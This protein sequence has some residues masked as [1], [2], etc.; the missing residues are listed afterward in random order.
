MTGWYGARHLH[1][2]SNVNHDYISANQIVNSV[3]LP[4]RSSWVTQY[5]C[6]HIRCMSTSTINISQN[7]TRLLIIYI[8]DNKRVAQSQVIQPMLS[9]T[10]IREQYPQFEFRYGVQAPTIVSRLPLST[11]YLLYSYSFRPKPVEQRPSVTILL[12]KATLH[13]VPKCAFSSSPLPPNFERIRPLC[14]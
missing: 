10:G 9:I 3:R 6:V 12:R 7:S 13:Q 5:T 14:H 11:Y 4:K 8:R 1:Q 2:Y